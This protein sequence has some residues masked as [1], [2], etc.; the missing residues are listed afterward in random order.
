MV[1]TLP[2]HALL[3]TIDWLLRVGCMLQAART[4]EPVWAATAARGGGS[5]TQ[6]AVTFRAALAI[7]LLPAG[8]VSCSGWTVA[9]TESSMRYTRACNYSIC[10]SQLSAR[11]QALASLSLTDLSG[12]A[13][14]AA[15]CSH[16]FY[17]CALVG[18]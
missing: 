16:W 2:V 3:L 12:S 14:A 13:A 1:G 4:I 5:A 8:P 15:L 11:W 18:H 17:R 9:N 10:Q 6:V 7:E